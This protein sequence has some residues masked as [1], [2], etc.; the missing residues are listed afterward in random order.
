M[1]IEIIMSFLSI[2]LLWVVGLHAI[3]IELLLIHKGG[4]P[5]LLKLV[6]RMLVMLLV[7]IKR[8]LLTL[9]GVRRWS[10]VLVSHFWGIR[11]CGLILMLVKVVILVSMLKV[12]LEVTGATAHRKFLVI[13]HRGL[14]VAIWAIV[15]VGVLISLVT[16]FRWG[17]VGAVLWWMSV[18]LLVEGVLI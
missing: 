13:F 7:L 10:M 12:P 6:L 16:H 18:W 1:G 9:C 4:L 17:H 14:H 5:M 3:M 15:P 2:G 11:H 8:L